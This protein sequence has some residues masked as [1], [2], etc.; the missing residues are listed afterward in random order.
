[1]STSIFNSQVI[2][3][4]TVILVSIFILNFILKFLFLATQDIC[5][6]EPYSIFHAQ[7]GVGDIIQFLKPT[8]NPPLFEIILHYWIKFFGI[9]PM[10]V[11]FLPLL[12]GSLTVIFIYKIAEKLFSLPVAIV[13]SLLYTFSTMSIYYSHDCRVYTLFLLLTTI[14]IYL[15]IKLFEDHSI[16]YKI[17]FCL[18]NALIIYAHYFGFF[19]WLIEAIYILYFGRKYLKMFALL[20]ILSVL[21]YLPQILV[22]VERF[23][24]SSTEGTW[25]KEVMDV[26]NLYNRLWSFCNMPVVVV[27]CILIMVIALSKKIYLTFKKEKDS[28]EHNSRSKLILIWF[29]VPYFL[30]FFI[31]LK[32]PIYLERYLIFILPAFYILIPFLINYIFSNEKIRNI[33]FLVLIL[34]FAATM[35]LNPDK[36]REAV[37]TIEFV[38]QNKDANTLVIVCAHDFIN[39]FA[40]YYDKKIFQNITPGKEY[41]TLTASMNAENIYPVRNINEIDQQVL[42]N[43]KKV[44]YLDAAADF[45]N[46]E[47]GILKT[48]ESKFTLKNK[49]HFN[50]IFEVYSFSN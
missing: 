5:I 15:F 6:D 37:K 48:L 21:I 2:K 18:V 20:F 12:F 40:Y 49:Q 42:E 44:I 43:F 8:N 26:E 32:V 23:H 38:K 39:N 29:F 41:E 46:P 22:F 25:I 17:S 33:M 3:N 11:R 35:Q 28:S 7:F 13:S 31:S 24:E 9:S 14:S 45:S 30:M 1:M 19:V 47:N 10:S 27:F 50:T 36:K 34:G 4:R 16:W